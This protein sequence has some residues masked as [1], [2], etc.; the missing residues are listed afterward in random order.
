M[1]WGLELVHRATGGGFEDDRVW[2][3][4]VGG[5]GEI[6]HRKEGRGLRAE[7]G[8]M[9]PPIA[10]DRLF[11]GFWVTFFLPS[12]G[13]FEASAQGQGQGELS[14]SSGPPKNT[15]RSILPNLID[16]WDRM[17]RLSAEFGSHE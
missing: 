1:L 6:H 7:E 5:E 3:F 14:M 12:C 11:I 17:L 4:V 2:N 15:K 8:R 10:G 13:A 9:I 16:A